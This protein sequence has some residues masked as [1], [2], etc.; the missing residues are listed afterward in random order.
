MAICSENEPGTNGEM[1]GHRPAPLSS[2]MDPEWFSRY[3]PTVVHTQQR[4]TAPH[5]RAKRVKPTLAESC[6]ADRTLLL[7][8]CP[9]LS[10]NAFMPL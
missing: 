7:A 1:G 5:L 4:S 2:T 3:T 10:D 6:D 8:L 9:A